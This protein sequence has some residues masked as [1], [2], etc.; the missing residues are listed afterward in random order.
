MVTYFSDF[1]N[2]P[3]FNSITDSHAELTSSI[4][5]ISSEGRPWI[6]HVHASVPLEIEAGVKLSNGSA[7]R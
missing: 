2:I 4:K 7:T 5:L 3:F 6:N 1:E